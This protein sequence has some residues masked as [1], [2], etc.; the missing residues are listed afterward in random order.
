MAESIG[1]LSF[2]RLDG[3]LN[4]KAIQ[5]EF[6]DRAFTDGKC[7]RRMQTRAEMSELVGLCDK[8]S[9]T[10][11]DAFQTACV[12]LQGTIVT[13]VFRGATKPNYYVHLVTPGEIIVGSTAVGGT[14]NGGCLV[15][16]RFQL[17]YVGT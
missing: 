8:A 1:G 3:A 10:S 7:V 17:V 5:G 6:I 12:A 16:V 15:M 2:I 4:R 14:T 11:G 13:V 9:T